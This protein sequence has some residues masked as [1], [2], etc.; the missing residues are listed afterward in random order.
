MKQSMYNIVEKVDDGCIIYNTFTGGIIHLNNQY[1][2]KFLDTNDS[3]EHFIENMLRGGFWV[4]DDVEEF[5]RVAEIS[6]LARNQLNQQGFTIA[7]TMACNFRCPYCFEDGRRYNTMSREIA[8]KTTTF[9]NNATS[10]NESLVISWYGGEPLLQPQLIESITKGI[11]NWSD[12]LSA[13]IITNGFFLDER[14]AEF[15]KSYNVRHAQVTI[16]GPPDIH[17]SRRCLPNG[18]DTFFVILKN[19]AQSCDYMSI[20]IR[21]NLDKTNLN[22][23]DE[24]F[25]YLDD[26]DLCGKVSLYL[27]TVD[28]IN[29]SIPSS[30]CLASHEFSDFEADFYSRNLRKGYTYIHLPSFNPSIC[31]AVSK[32]MCVIDPSGNLYK[33]WN[34]VNDVTKSY[35]SVLYPETNNNLSLW[36]EYDF[37]QYDE[38]NECKFLPICMGGC[39]YHAI[40]SNKKNCVTAK[41]NYKQML[42][43][44]KRIKLEMNGQ[45]KI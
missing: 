10:S 41:Y 4:A 16:D 43:L 40:V 45:T 24:I 42:C 5:S 14:M 7:P 9:I 44:M 34:E 37:L 6:R 21:I 20:S 32:S 22:R 3:D 23:A 18:N 17:N 39:P 8:E 19:I 38:C 29:D 15:L 31:G 27:A 13:S 36:Q 35:G 26:F 1:E 11:D 28:D 25:E 2:N 12:R 30:I 33:C